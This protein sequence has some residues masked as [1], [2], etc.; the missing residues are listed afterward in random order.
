MK[1]TKEELDYIHTDVKIN[2]TKV[3][4]LQLKKFRKNSW[5]PQDKERVIKREVF[6][7]TIL[8][9]IEYLQGENN[10]RL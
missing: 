7:R 6:L 9:K 8:D 1:F 5:T 2:L 10:E 3:R 4:G